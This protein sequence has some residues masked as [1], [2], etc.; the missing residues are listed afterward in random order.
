M[1]HTLPDDGISYMRLREKGGEDMK[2]IIDGSPVSSGPGQSLLELVHRLGLDTDSLSTQPLAAKI[3]GEV[4]T[5]NYI[6]VRKKEAQEERQSMRRA[7]EASGGVVKLLRYGDPTGKDVY[8]RTMLFV[9]FLAVEQLWP[10]AVAKVNHTVGAGLF[11]SVSVIL[12]DV[13]FP[14]SAKKHT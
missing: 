13:S 14:S 5:L 3:A 6:P 8:V 9:T 11:V 12:R 2:L 4:F 7:M 1:Q 10:K